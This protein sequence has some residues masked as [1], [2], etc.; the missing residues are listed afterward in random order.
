MNASRVILKL[1]ALHEGD[2]L[3]FIDELTHS[4][5]GFYPVERCRMQRVETESPDAM[6]AHVEAECAFEW[7]TLKDKSNARAG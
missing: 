3:D 7:I 2:V 4:R 1:R 6:Q 5:Q